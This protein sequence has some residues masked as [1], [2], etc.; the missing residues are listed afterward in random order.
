MTPAEIATILRRRM[1]HPERQA[2]EVFLRNDTDRAPAERFG[3]RAY[4]PSGDL[5]PNWTPERGPWPVFFSAAGYVNS[6]RWAALFR[7]VALDIEAAEAFAREV[8]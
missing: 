7:D 6:L 1:D 2:G 8:S 5:L 3:Q 4:L